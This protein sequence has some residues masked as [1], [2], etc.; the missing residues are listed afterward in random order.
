[1]SAAEES[2]SN[3]ER[4]RRLADA[5]KARNELAK[6]R[7]EMIAKGKVRKNDFDKDK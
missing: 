5:A 1:M 6:A 2:E 3:A 4:D 7:A